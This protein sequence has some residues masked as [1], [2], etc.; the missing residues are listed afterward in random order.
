VEPFPGR[1]SITAR[2]RGDGSGGGPLLLLSH[3]DVVPAPGDEWTHDPFAA[4]VADGYVFGRGAV[5]MKAMVAM[6]LGIVRL[7]ASETRAAGRDP[8]G[9]PVPSLRRDIVFTATADEEAGG[10]AGARWLV[11][12]RPEWLQ[13]DGAL[14]EA[15]GVSMEM[16][17]RRFYPIQVAEKGFIVYRLAV[18]GTAGHGSMPR[19]DNAAVLAARIVE[20]VAEPG[21]GRLTPVMERLFAAVGAEAPDLT[22]ALAA[23]A[24]IDPRRS[25]A[26]LAGLC[27]PMVARVASALLRDTVS[28]NVLHAGVKYNVIPGEAVIELDVR[29]L[30]G[31]TEPGMREELRR[32]ISEELWAATEVEVVVSGEP[33]EAPID[34]DLYRI[35]ADT[36]RDHDPEAIPVAAMAPFSTDAKSTALRLGVPT[37]GFS[38]LRM[39]PEERFLDRFH[40]VDERVSLEALRFGLPVLYDVVRRFCG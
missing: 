15:G 8:A 12:H 3:L 6:E 23:A 26:G 38:P 27:D 14:N 7:L 33:V 35:M 10:L 31:T 29:Q 22:R 9:D 40:G 34:T 37:Y 19:A 25:E 2:L 21:V 5:D 18:K 4:D 17:G 20:R 28:P 16:G 13:A 32:R 36:L 24:D 1:G 39:A 11:D 30:P